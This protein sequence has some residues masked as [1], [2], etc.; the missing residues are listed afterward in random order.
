MQLRNPLSLRIALFFLIPV[1][2]AI[3]H[4]YVWRQFSNLIQIQFGADKV[5]GMVLCLAAT[6]YFLWHAFRGRPTG[7]SEAHDSFGIGVCSAI[8]AVTFTV[9][10]LGYE[11]HVLK[12]MVVGFLYS[13]AAFFF[14][15]SYKGYPLRAIKNRN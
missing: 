14:W 5:V 8:L 6:A 15:W 10:G 1:G 11:H 9:S 4:W 13:T 2:I 12:I 3:D 7:D